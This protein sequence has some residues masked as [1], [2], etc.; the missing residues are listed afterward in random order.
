MLTKTEVAPT[1][2]QRLRPRSRRPSLCSALMFCF[3]AVAGFFAPSVSVANALLSSMNQRDVSLRNL[4]LP[5]PAYASAPAPS[6]RNSNPRKPAGV[7]MRS[8]FFDDI[9]KFF[10]PSHSSNSNN[11]E[12]DSDSSSLGDSDDEDEDDDATPAGTTRIVSIPVQSIKP[13]GLRLFLMF[14]LLGMQNTPDK[15]T[16]SAN[17][18]STDEYVLEFWFRDRSAVL[19]LTLESNRISLDRTGSSP[20]VAYLMQETSVVQ[21]ILDELQQMASDDQVDVKDRLLVL[22]HPDSIQRARDSLAFS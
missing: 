7:V 10:D 11:K 9:F 5:R 4:P 2:P 3:V 14:Y 15:N 16:W 8:S 13:G 20:S 22:A 17:Q 19:T 21:G 18:P 6:R 1:Q 12:S